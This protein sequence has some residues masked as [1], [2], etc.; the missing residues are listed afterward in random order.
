MREQQLRGQ[1]SSELEL[2][3]M[4]P[5]VLTGRPPDARAD[6][7]TMGALAAY[8]VTGAAAVRRV[9][10]ARAH[11]P[12]A[13]AAAAGDAARRGAAGRR[14]GDHAGLAADP[15]ARGAMSELR[16]AVRAAAPS[17]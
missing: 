7:F 13:A 12:D 3:Y 5:E 2:P 15:A 16:A 6:L 14:A 8:L 10:P 9:E 4:A 11:R 1:E 17:S